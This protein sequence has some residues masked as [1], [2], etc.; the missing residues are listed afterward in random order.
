MRDQLCIYLYTFPKNDDEMERLLTNK[1]V[2]LKM[3]TDKFYL[4]K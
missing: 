1:Q 2:W 3:G 4:E